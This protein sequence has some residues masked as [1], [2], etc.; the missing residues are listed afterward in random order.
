MITQPWDTVSKVP[1]HSSEATLCFLP[2]LT[3][4]FLMTDTHVS[5]PTGNWIPFLCG[6]MIII[7]TQELEPR[8]A[9]GKQA[10]SKEN[11][12]LVHIHILAA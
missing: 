6:H 3:P 4:C 12:P 7:R 11:K 2:L 9:F 5:V 10:N 1:I 8:S